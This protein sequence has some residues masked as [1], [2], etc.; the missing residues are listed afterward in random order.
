MMDYRSG[1]LPPAV[2]AAFVHHLGLCPNCER[3]LVSY[4]QTVLLGRRAFD[5]DEAA[6]PAEVP[7]DLVTAILA[8]RRFG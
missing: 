3:Y 7:E 6:V 8:A 1:E 5:D 2:R 4:E